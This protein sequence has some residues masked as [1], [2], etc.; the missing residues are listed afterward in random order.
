MTERRARVVVVDDEAIELDNI[1]RA[2]KREGWQYA[3]FAD[4]VKA[5]EDIRD[6]EYD[7]GLFD[8]RMPNM[9]GIELMRRVQAL[10]K[11]LDV[12]VLTAHGSLD[13]ASEAVRLGA[14][15]YIL[16]PYPLAHLIDVVKRTLSTRR[17]RQQLSTLHELTLDFVA[18]ENGIQTL[19]DQLVDGVAAV[20]RPGLVCLA[21]GYEQGAWRLLASEGLDGSRCA[22]AQAGIPEG[23]EKIVNKSGG[24]IVAA[25][26]GKLPLSFKGIGSALVAPMMSRG[27]I[28]GALYIG[29][30]DKGAFTDSPSAEEEFA[31]TQEDLRFVTVMAGLGA[32]AVRQSRDALSLREA[33]NAQIR[34]Q[35][36]AA[37]A[38]A[39]QGLSRW[40]AHAMKNALWI[41]SGRAELL[42]AKAKETKL[43]DGLDVII[44]Q[45]GEVD[46]IMGKF[47]RAAMG[48]DSRPRPSDFS[49]LLSSAKE[50]ALAR[51]EDK[52][53]LIKVEERCEGNPVL[54]ADPVELKQALVNILAN[55]VRAMLPDGGTLSITTTCA[56]NSLSLEVRDTGY[57]ISPEN[58]KQLFK[59]FFSTTSGGM[60]LGLWTT[61]HIIENHGGTIDIES[62]LGKGTTV[63]VS[64]PLEGGK[65]D[66]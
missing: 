54:E 2:L 56:G 64:L 33:M 34:A 35:A 1:S 61:K 21:V 5:L 26:A 19:M 11:D 59:P 6:Q 39:T 14:S 9:N 49:R 13:T 10:Q 31:R 60:G 27:E 40:V 36:R 8:I 25:D 20:L 58:Q 62:E 7:I 22:E 38:E 17:F 37:Q 51:Y 29:S 28:L 57:G 44:K 23:L 52:R 48:T 43:Q 12:I 32:A 30:P 50:E 24:A 45:A 16:R 55:A 47:R 46:K 66:A 15:D 63:R 4:P 18:S 42:R 3:T 65:T 41:I 53:S